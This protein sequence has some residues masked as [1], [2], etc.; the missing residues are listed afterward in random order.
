MDGLI[1]VVGGSG[2]IGRYVVQE[3]CRTGVRVRVVTREPTG[4]AYLKPLGGLGQVEIVAGDVRRPATLAAACDGADGVINLVG[5]LA[6]GSGG[7]FTSIHARGAESVAAAAARAGASAFVQISAIGADPE[8]PSAYGRSKAQGEA[9][10]RAAFAGATILRPSIVFG[11][12][13]AFINRFAGLIAMAPVVPVVAPRVR[14]QPVYALDLARAIVAAVGDPARFGGRTYAIG[15]PKTYTMRGLIEWIM[16]E[17]YTRKAVIEVPDGI[18]SLLATLTGWLPG[19]P[20]TR[21]QLAMLG[22]DNV[23]ES[24][25]LTAFGIRATPLEAVA[26]AYLVRYR[27][28][29]RFNP[30]PAAN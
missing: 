12:E 2:F 8:S 1:T 21:D 28:H 11:P 4:A 17:T 23:A 19:A 15:G 6:E 5:I 24:D 20:I 29:G 18:A 10:V 25:G 9:A 7:G 26:P 16:A 27:R 13:D 30:G 3:L 14:F 22:R